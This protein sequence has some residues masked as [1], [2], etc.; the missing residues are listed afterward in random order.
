MLKGSSTKPRANYESNDDVLVQTL[1]AVSRSVVEKLPDYSPEARLEFSEALNAILKQFSEADSSKLNV[2][3]RFSS[4]LL[5]HSLI[6]LREMETKDWENAFKGWIEV[7]A[8]RRL[9]V[10][11]GVNPVKK[12]SSDPTLATLA[13]GTLTFFQYLWRENR[14]WALFSSSSILLTVF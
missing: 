14:V 1:K 4:I 7:V 9:S 2:A 12:E 3:L 5:K 11:Q 13:E 6:V 10:G 8:R